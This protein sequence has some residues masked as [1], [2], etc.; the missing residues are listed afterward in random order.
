MQ[1]LKCAAS[2]VPSGMYILH[3]KLSPPS[4]AFTPLFTVST[5]LSLSLY[6]SG[7]F[8]GGDAHRGQACLQLGH[9][10]F[11][12]LVGVQLGEQIVVHVRRVFGAPAVR[13]KHLP[14]DL[15]HVAERRKENNNARTPGVLKKKLLWKHTL[16]RTRTQIRWLRLW[17][18]WFWKRGAGSSRVISRRFPAVQLWRRSFGDAVSQES[19]RY[20]WRGNESGVFWGGYAILKEDEVWQRWSEKGGATCVLVC[21][22]TSSFTAHSHTQ[23][24]THTR[25]RTHTNRHTQTHPFS[26]NKTAT[27]AW[28]I[29]IRET[30]YTLILFLSKSFLAHALA[31]F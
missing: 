26:P 13:E 6:L 8:P 10:H 15:I 9:I 29:S 25:A 4:A 27:I 1:S 14:Y 2:P 7:S 19:R 11:S 23:S 17:H 28:R 21:L 30:I 20:S 16:T 22:K 24:A 12:I 31:G 5:S 3:N 18:F